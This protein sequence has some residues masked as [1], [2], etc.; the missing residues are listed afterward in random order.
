[1]RY[2]EALSL[3]SQSACYKFSVAKTH[4]GTDAYCRPNIGLNPV[5]LDS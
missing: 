2:Y 1:M 4:C 5:T 3:M